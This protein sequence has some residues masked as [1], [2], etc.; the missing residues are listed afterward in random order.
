MHNEMRQR[1]TSSFIY[2]LR[3]NKSIDRTIF[4]ELLSC[5]N[6]YTPIS[7]YKY[8][9][10]GAESFEE[11]RPL[12]KNFRISDMISLEL[13]ENMVKRQFF[14]RP[15][16][17]IKIHHSRSGDYID[18]L[19]RDEEQNNIIIWLDYTSTESK[20]QIEEFCRLVLKL[21]PKDIVRITMNAHPGTLGRINFRM[22]DIYKTRRIK[23][24]ERLG[25][26]SPPDILDRDVKDDGFVKL[27]I[28]VLKKTLYQTMLTAA[29]P[30][31]FVL[32][33]SNTYADGQQMLTI[34]GMIAEDAAEIQK[35]LESCSKWEYS[36]NNNWDKLEKIEVPKLTLREKIELNQL[37]ASYDDQTI[38]NRLGY[39]L[40]GGDD[41]E[42]AIKNYRRYYRQY[43]SYQQII[44]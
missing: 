41:A 20:I 34:T 43:P 33:S 3:P 19:K 31:K 42:Q 35:I 11:Y 17:F 24:K 28:R 32:L 30:N 13:D 7:G 1:K 8:I 25:E 40:S 23:L 12:H 18:Q 36:C 27:L 37:L 5:V 39:S 21:R 14:N 10:F 9:G 16:D 44:I 38:A 6:Q 2:A 29:Y 4:M 22:D 15:Y 26:L